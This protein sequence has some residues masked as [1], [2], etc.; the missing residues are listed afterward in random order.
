[1][2]FIHISAGEFVIIFF[3]IYLIANFISFQ[4]ICKCIFNKFYGL[5]GGLDAFRAVDVS[6]FKRIGKS[7]Q[8]KLHVLNE[9]T[10][11]LL[12]VLAFLKRTGLFT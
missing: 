7:G 5:F 9:D 4:W 2:N 1:M 11:R 8:A 12:R 10:I 3:F 6:A